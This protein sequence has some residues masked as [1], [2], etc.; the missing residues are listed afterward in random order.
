MKERLSATAK[1]FGKLELK[2]NSNIN[3]LGKWMKGYNM[4]NSSTEIE[5]ATLNE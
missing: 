3:R 5:I 4:K 2:Q 1:L